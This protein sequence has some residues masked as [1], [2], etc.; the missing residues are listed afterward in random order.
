M[1][2]GRRK[3]ITLHSFFIKMSLDIETEVRFLNI[4]EKQLKEK[5]KHLGAKDL[6]EDFLSEIIYYDKK[7]EWLRD[8]KKLVRLR[9]QKNLLI[10]CYNSS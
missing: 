4:D 8:G 3:L 5:L 6:G 10:L 7:L 2:C 1:A 9:K